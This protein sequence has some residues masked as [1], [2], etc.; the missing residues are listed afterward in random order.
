MTKHVNTIHSQ[1]H[2][3]YTCGEMF[4]TMDSLETHR[5][6]IHVEEDTV[7]D[8]SFVFRESML[9]EFL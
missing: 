5:E 8:A 6:T 1:F 3:C 2:K 7:R 4:N 9:D